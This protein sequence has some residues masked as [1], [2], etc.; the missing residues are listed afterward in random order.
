M[1]SLK[2][3]LDDLAGEDN[4]FPQGNGLIPVDENFET[5]PSAGLKAEEAKEEKQTPIRFS[6]LIQ[7]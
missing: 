4:P 1:I 5:E 7:N 2:K 6:R 3:F